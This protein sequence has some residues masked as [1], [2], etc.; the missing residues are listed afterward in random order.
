MLDDDLAPAD[1]LAYWHD[2]AG[3]VKVESP[4]HVDASSGLEQPELVS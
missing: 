3:H 1:L 4:H 2:A